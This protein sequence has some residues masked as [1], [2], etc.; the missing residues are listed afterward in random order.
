MAVTF[1]LSS[2]PE[3]GVL[4]TLEINEEE[5]GYHTPWHAKGILVECSRKSRV[6]VSL[7]GDRFRPSM[8]AIPLRVPLR[9]NRT[10]RGSVHMRVPTCSQDALG[11]A[12]VVN[13]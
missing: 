12:E 4:D 2:K 6:P 9:T 7:L 8:S 11:W 10:N 5:N 13:A 1:F 3:C